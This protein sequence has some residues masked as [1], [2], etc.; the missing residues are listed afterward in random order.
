MDTGTRRF[1]WRAFAS[2]ATAFSFVIMAV[3]GIVLFVSP[4]GRISRVTEWSFMG[5][6]RIQLINLHVWFSLI[7][8]I[9]SIAHLYFN[10]RVMLSYITKRGSRLEWIAA[11]IIC[12]LIFAGTLIPAPPFSTLNNLRSEYR[13]CKDRGRNCGGGGGGERGGGRGGGKGWRGGRGSQ[14]QSNDKDL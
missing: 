7:F 6:D 14:D 2:S 4:S 10:W 5:L 1:K 9:V 8:V 12:G 13:G 11:L 3:T